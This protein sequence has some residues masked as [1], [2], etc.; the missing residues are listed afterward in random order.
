VHYPDVDDPVHPLTEDELSNVAL[1][2]LLKAAVDNKE[3][4]DEQRV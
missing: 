4:W 2:E 1:D 3:A